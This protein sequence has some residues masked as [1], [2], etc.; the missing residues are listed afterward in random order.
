[1]TTS[2]QEKLDLEHEA[3][4]L[5]MRLYERQFG[6]PMRHIWHNEPR[7]PDV[8]CYLEGEKLDLEIAHLYGSEAE[9]ILIHKREINQR[10]IEAL[11]RLL[12]VPISQRLLAAL[13]TILASKA[14]KKYHSERVWLVLRN[15]NPLWTRADLEANLHHVTLPKAHPFEQIW[16][17][18][19][20]NGESGIVQLFP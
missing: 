16:V 8:S 13:N 14:E 2:A 5:F 18:G 6:V 15:T 3:A 9:A 19:D 10:T 1:M 4:K 7:K 12:D 11:H 17:V 20:M